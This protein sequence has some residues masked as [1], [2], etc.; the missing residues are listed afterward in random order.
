MGTTQGI[1][2]S[3]LASIDRAFLLWIRTSVKEHMIRNLFLTVGKL[4]DFRTKAIAAPKQS[5]FSLAKV[6]WNHCVALD[7]QLAERESICKTA[8]TTVAHEWPSPK[9]LQIVSAGENVEKKE[10]SHCW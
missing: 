5:L 10:P 8:N 1:C 3:E 4:A 2:N 6:V 7:C 9:I